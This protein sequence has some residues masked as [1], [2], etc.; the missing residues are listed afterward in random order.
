MLG[1]GDWGGK[2]GLFLDAG[3]SRIVRG[4]RL[5]QLEQAESG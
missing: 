4:V 3:V 5:Y 2:S 1:L